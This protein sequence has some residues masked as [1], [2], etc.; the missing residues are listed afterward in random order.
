MDALAAFRQKFPECECVLLNTCNRV[1]FYVGT[2]ERELPS[3]EELI[4]FV[5]GF[6]NEPSS[7]F[8]QHFLKLE[9]VPAIQHLFS[10][11]S[12]IDSIV[13]GKLK[14]RRKLTTHMFEQPKVDLRAP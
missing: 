2:N 6:H 10:V 13:L 12:S 1:E 8:E 11:A 14:S 9:S 7:E 4:G 3:T 5:T